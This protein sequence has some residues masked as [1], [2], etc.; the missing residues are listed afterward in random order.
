MTSVTTPTSSGHRREELK[1]LDRFQRETVSNTMKITD[2]RR[3]NEMP[4][5]TQWIFYQ[6]CDELIRLYAKQQRLATRGYSKEICLIIERL[7]KFIADEDGSR[8][9][10]SG[11]WEMGMISKAQVDAWMELRSIV[12]AM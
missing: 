5:L 4:Q 2:Y 11:G 6:L 9:G 8:F 10:H 1:I 12:L 3:M 7:L